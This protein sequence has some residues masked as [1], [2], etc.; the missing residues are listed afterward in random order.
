MYLDMSGEIELVENSLFD[1]KVP[2]LIE[3][4]HELVNFDLRSWSVELQLTTLQHGT[5]RHF[6]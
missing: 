2:E 5:N 4:L 6:Q 3:D 1:R